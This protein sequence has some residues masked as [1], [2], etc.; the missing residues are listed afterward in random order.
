M[1]GVQTC[2]L[3]IAVAGDH[4]RAMALLREG[5]RRVPGYIRDWPRHDPDLE[6]LRNDPEF[7]AEFNTMFSESDPT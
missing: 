1:T 5:V 4:K 3:P 7:M 6:A 2:A